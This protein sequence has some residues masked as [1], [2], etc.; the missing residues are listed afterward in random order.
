MYALSLVL[1]SCALIGSCFLNASTLMFLYRLRVG[2]VN[3]TLHWAYYLTCSDVHSLCECSLWSLFIVIVLVWS[4]HALLL[5]SLLLDRIVLAL[6]AFQDFSL[7]WT[8]CVIVFKNTYL[9]GSRASQ[10]LELG[11]S[12]FWQLF[13]T[14]I[15]SLE[16]ILGFC[17]GIAKGGD[18]KVEFI[19]PCVDF[20]SC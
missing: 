2:H 7:Q 9:Y 3:D 12:E 19:Q 5:Y 16:Y 11:V 15:L 20:I 4:S 8:S 13:P 10:N 18:C 6:Y 17:H 1:Y 14:H